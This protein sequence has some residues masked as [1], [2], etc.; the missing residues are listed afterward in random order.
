MCGFPILN[1]E[2]RNSFS[3]LNIYFIYL[4]INFSEL[5][6]NMG[7]FLLMNK[8]IAVSNTQTRLHA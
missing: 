7:L 3:I 6:M 1:Q 2:N 8:F 5:D 4:F